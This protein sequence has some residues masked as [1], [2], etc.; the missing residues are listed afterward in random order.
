MSR[1]FNNPPESLKLFVKSASTTMELASSAIES[2]DA[3]DC[4]NASRFAFR[5]SEEF[6]VVRGIMNRI[7]ADIRSSEGK[8]QEELHVLLSAMRQDFDFLQKSKGDVFRKFAKRCACSV[9][10]P[11]LPSEFTIR[12]G[13][14][15]EDD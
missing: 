13:D 4:R 5:M 7:T 2:A 1:E 8:Q 9:S 12:P 14:G 3:G 10:S 6:G 15:E 11:E